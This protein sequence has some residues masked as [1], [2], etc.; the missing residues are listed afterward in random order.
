MILSRKQLLN[1][2]MEMLEFPISGGYAHYKDGEGMYAF[3]DFKNKDEIKMFML[4]R[5]RDYGKVANPEMTRKFG[6]QFDDY[7]S[8]SG[9]L[10]KDYRK[11]AKA[12]W[13]KFADHDFFSNN[14]ATLHQI[15]Y[16]GPSDS[17]K[18]L[19]TRY[20]AGETDLSAFGVKSKTPLKP[21][22]EEVRAIANN[23]KDAQARATT[24]LVLD[25][26]ISWCGDFDAY[27][28]EFKAHQGVEKKY[29]DSRKKAMDITKA[30]GRVP[31]RPGS[32]VLFDDPEENLSEFPI[33]LDEEDVDALENPLIDE[34][35]VSNWTVSGI[36]LYIENDEAASLKDKEVSDVAD[37]ANKIYRERNFVT[38]FHNLKYSI[39]ETGYTNPMILDVDLGRYYT[40][41][42]VKE[43]FSL[44]DKI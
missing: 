9:Q 43:L 23:Y 2:I 26:R 3:P 1:L 6:T 28:E 38:P 15:G 7:D 10:A 22:L 12:L 24:Y 34:I 16:A 44:L 39:E 21:S 5:M 18:G 8:D 32:A 40:E 36:I 17:K 14:I 33:L 35:I 19:S 29:D 20:L 27:T 41:E 11:Y 31:K 30:A 25:G 13:N 42:E 4:K 37:F